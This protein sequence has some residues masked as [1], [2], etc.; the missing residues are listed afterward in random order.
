MQW[1]RWYHNSCFTE[2]ETKAQRGHKAS[3]SAAQGSP[4]Y[5][6][7]RSRSCIN[8]HRDRQEEWTRHGVSQTF[9]PWPPFSWGHVQGLRWSDTLGERWTPTGG[10]SLL[11]LTQPFLQGVRCNGGGGHALNHAPDPACC[12]RISRRRHLSSFSLTALS[13][14]RPPCGHASR[15]RLPA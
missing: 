1:G 11:L 5:L 7:H 8:I 4:Q 15:L 12:P 3:K 10:T 6:Y 14:G 9:W 2:K 13:E